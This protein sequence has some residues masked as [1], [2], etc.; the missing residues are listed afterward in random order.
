M[1]YEVELKFAAPDLAGF[2]QKLIALGHAISPPSDEVDLYFAHPSIDFA[3]TDQALRLRRRGETNLITY[4]G[5][6]IDQATKTRQE[7]ELPL[8]VGEA[9]FKSWKTLLEALAF[10]PVG[11]VRKVRRK[12]YIF[13]HDWKVEASLDEVHHAGTFVEFEVDCEEKDL[14]SARECILTLAES[15]GL[16][17]SERRSY[18]SLVLGNEEKK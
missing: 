1:H 5:P 15:L 13:W 11:E 10:K 17:K 9:S 6:K 3:K 14:D 16:T 4:K 8:A 2:T 12:A 18:L 7:L